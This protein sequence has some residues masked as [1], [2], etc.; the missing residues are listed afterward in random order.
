MQSVPEYLIGCTCPDD[1]H[2]KKYFTLYMV[3]SCDWKTYSLV[4][5][6]ETYFP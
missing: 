3:V 2:L 1:T 6:F 4:K 5:E